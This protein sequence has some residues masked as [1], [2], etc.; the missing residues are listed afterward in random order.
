LLLLL[1]IMQTTPICEPYTAERQRNHLIGGRHKHVRAGHG[2]WVILR[3]FLGEKSTGSD[4]IGAEK[5]VRAAGSPAPTSADN[6]IVFYTR[7]K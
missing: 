7:S 3:E 5:V 4:V 1:L 6:A 2:G